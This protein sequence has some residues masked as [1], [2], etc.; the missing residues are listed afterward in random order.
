M[1]ATRLPIIGYPLPHTVLE[2]VLR[3]ALTDAGSPIQL[4]QREARPH[5]LAD[6][7]SEVRAG[8][9]F[10]G[11]ADRIAAQGEGC[12]AVGL[13]QRRRAHRAAR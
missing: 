1:P 8:D 5:Q 9:D 3:R 11:D 10:V 4:E 7:L 2:G 6:A 13:A 12:T